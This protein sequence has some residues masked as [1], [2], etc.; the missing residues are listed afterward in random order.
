MES[1]NPIDSVGQRN[2]VAVAK[3][4]TRPPTVKL[5][6]TTRKTPTNMEAATAVSGISSRYTQM[7]AINPAFFSSVDLRSLASAANLRAAW[8][9]RPN[10]F[11]T[12]IP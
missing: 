7:L 6:S 3:K 9:P 10:A 11:R 2:T 5:P 4:A 8:S 12:L 1:K